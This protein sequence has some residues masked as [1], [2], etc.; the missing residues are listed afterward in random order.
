MEGFVFGVK[1]ICISEGWL[2]ST[3]EMPQYKRRH[4]SHLA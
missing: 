1:S 2:S 4:M 3:V